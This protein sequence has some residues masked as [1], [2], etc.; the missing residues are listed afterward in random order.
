MI[1]EMGIK[2]RLAQ[3]SFSKEDLLV[4]LQ[5]T[6]QDRKDLLEAASKR[7]ILELG[8]KVFF[9]G[10]IEYSNRCSKDCYYCGIRRS[11]QK[12]DRYQIPDAEVLEAVRFAFENR[13]ASLVIQ[14]GEQSS[15]SFRKRISGLLEQIQSLTGGSMGITL[16]LGEQDRETLEEWFML[17]ANRYLLRVEASNPKLYELLHPSTKL[18]DYGQR[19]EQLRTLQEIGYQV[20]TGV[21]IGLPFQTL[22]DLAEDLLFFRDQKIDMVGMGPY[23]EHAETPLYRFRDQIP[24][25]KERFDL[26]LKMIACLRLLCPDINIAATTAMQT[27]DPQGRE[28]AVWVGAN[29]I[30]PNLTPVKYREGYQLY[31]DKPCLNEEASDCI[32]CLEARLKMAG[33]VVGYGETGDS[34]KYLRRVKEQ[35][36]PV[37]L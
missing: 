7:K 5:T 34:L 18:H 20:G 3:E 26:S 6:G 12:F 25:R 19:V 37:F 28:K 31:A 36:D 29:V 13:Y 1:L 17:G 24:D 21:M 32:N 33:A 10:L 22:E 14:S 16:S 2:E 11:N 15:K 30:M 4:F 9:R 23:I 27:L 8:N 35:S